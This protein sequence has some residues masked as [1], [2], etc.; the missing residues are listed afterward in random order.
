MALNWILGAATLL[1]LAVGVLAVRMIGRTGL[2][3]GLPVVIAFFLLAVRHGSAFFHYQAVGTAGSAALVSELIMLILAGL[4]VAGLMR[5]QPA[6]LVFKES[7]AHYRTLFERAPIGIG[8]ADLDGNLLLYNQAMLDPGGYTRE[9]IAEI[10]NVARLYADPEERDR[11]LALAREQGHVYR[12]EVRFR[13]KDGGSYDTLL[14]L[15]PVQIGGRSGWQAI[16]EDITQQKQ[17][18]LEYTELRHQLES[19]QRLE[20][21]GR[22]AGGIAHDFNNLLTATLSH[23]ELVLSRL[24]ED[25]PNRADVR[26]IERS[27]HRAADLIRQ[28]LAFSRKQVLKPRT[29]DLNA[30]I[31]QAKT[32]LRRVIGEHIELVTAIDEDLGYVKA[33]PA[34]IEQVIMNLAVNARDAMPEGGRLTIR[35]SNVELG[36]DYV[37][38][39][40]TVRPGRYV[41]LS[42]SDTGHGMDEAVR[43]RVFE[44]FFTT[45]ELGRGTGLGLSTVYG[46]VKQS[47]G[48]IWV[49][50]EQNHGTT[51]KIYL[52]RVPEGVEAELESPR[53][54]RDAPGGRETILLVEDE[55]AV[56]EVVARLLRN[57]GYTVL[58]AEQPLD[59]LG[60]VETKQHDI[61]L[62][63]TDVVMPGINGK[64][65]AERVRQ[66]RPDLKVMYMSGYSGT[67]LESTGMAPEA[68][69]LEKPFTQDELA[70]RVRAALDEG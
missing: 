9:D 7:E 38:S 20:A 1:Q 22:L 53:E 2:Y 17:A 13:K 67:H 50:S 55:S 11:T 49:Y 65:L 56:R 3:S 4:M 6:L 64:D 45:K 47:E 35:A 59:A 26:E 23:A 57:H 15:T 10:G 32:F 44:P 24:E 69:L 61:D 14:S 8:V 52:P 33:D 42:V 66:V 43:S 25:D 70:A 18:E 68:M 21:V 58:E 40:E 28:L 63:L 36:E 60:L 16:V 27:A 62:L 41:M 31:G 19:S 5:V 12:R 51:F 34:Q 30:A 29:L 54:P 37:A 48:Y 39:H 46:I